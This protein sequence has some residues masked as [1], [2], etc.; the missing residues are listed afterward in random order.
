MALLLLVFC[1]LSSHT[2]RYDCACSS[3]RL[4]LHLG[5]ADP[6]DLLMA[7]LLLVF[8]LLSSHA[9]AGV[10]IFFRENPTLRC[11]TASQ[12]VLPTS[13]DRR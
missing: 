6:A 3:P 7:L 1:L 2:L 10:T 4:S 8:R 9:L 13:P 12:V 11:E 5:E